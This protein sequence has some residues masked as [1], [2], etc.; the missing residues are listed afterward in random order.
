MTKQEIIDKARAVMNEIGKEGK[1]SLLSEDTVR[2]S[3]YIESV[4]PDAVNLIARSEEVSSA[5]L[6]TG[7]ITSGGAASVDPS[8]GCAI[9]ALPEDFLRFVA[10][11]LSGWK[12][13][14]QSVAP[15]GDNEYKI[16]H[17]PVT[18][19]GVNKPSCVFA[20]NAEGLCIECFPSGTLQYFRYVKK[21]TDM[22]DGS[23]NKYGDDLLPAIGYACAYLVYN[24]FEMPDVADRMLKIAFQVVPT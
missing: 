18:R 16:Q 19:S 21:L 2:L 24:I 9:I 10:L 17:N 5:S 20:Y 4:I 22:E 6:N 11:R 3:E 15:Y 7:N 14:V 23:I 13:E 8:D 1:L 12:R